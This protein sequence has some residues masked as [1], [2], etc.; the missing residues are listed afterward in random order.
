MTIPPGD[1]E[2]NVSIPI[3]NNVRVEKV[4]IFN[5]LL[6]SNDGSVAIGFPN[7]SRVAIFDDDSKTI[8]CV[9]NS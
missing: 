1:T 8:H 6:Y 9:D 7:Q 3:Y 5:V 2:A 4:E